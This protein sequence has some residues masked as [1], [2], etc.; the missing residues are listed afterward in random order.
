MERPE[1]EVRGLGFEA[2]SRVGC[3]PRIPG[4]GF[5]VGTAWFGAGKGSAD[6]V[7][8]DLVDAVKTALEAGYRHLDNAEAYANEASVGVAI[9]ESGISR[10]ELYICTKTGPGIKDIPGNFRLQL[11]KLGVKYVDLLLIHWPYDFG[12]DGK[13]SNEEAWKQLEILKDEGLA[14]SIG[15]S[16]YRISDLKKTL[17]IARHRPVVNQIEYHPYLVKESEAL[18]SFMKAEGIALEAY[19]PTSPVTKHTGGPIDPVL[20]KV[21]ASVSERAGKKVEPSQVLLKLSSQ[22][23]AIVITTSGKRFR[24]EEQLAAGAIPDLTTEE[25]DD[26]KAA[27][28]KD[29]KRAFMKHMESE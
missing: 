13:P 9:A 22:L 16:N 2:Y 24:M 3:F 6:G 26:L 19:G 20:S 15:V 8:R 11:K 12:K 1:G 25:V 4:I 23:G 27:G 14:K 28:A 18:I 10:N 21:T 5:G 7:S 17:A 29:Y